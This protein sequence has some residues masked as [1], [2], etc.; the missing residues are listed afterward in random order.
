M[1][2]CCETYKHIIHLYKNIKNNIYNDIKTALSSTTIINKYVNRRYD[3]SGSN[4]IGLSGI[5][6]FASGNEVQSYIKVSGG[7]SVTLDN[8]N[9][10]IF[11]MALLYATD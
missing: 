4:T 8:A 6:K 3:I 5:S 7:G 2:I 11:S 1:I 10:S 9:E